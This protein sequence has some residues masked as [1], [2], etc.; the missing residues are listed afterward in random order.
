MDNIENF[1]E[2]DRYYKKSSTSTNLYTLDAYITPDFYHQVKLIFDW[3]TNIRRTTIRDMN[4]ALLKFFGVQK[5]TQKI[6][7]IEVKAPHGAIRQDQ[8]AF[9][10]DLMHRKVIHGIARSTD[11]A[12]KIVKEGLIGYGYPD[13]DKKI[14]Y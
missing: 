5:D 11:D 3:I 14:W 8:L 9:H 4:N 6:F 13:T 1:V 2:N 7:F 10:A 12:L